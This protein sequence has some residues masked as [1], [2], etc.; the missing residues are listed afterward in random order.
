LSLKKF[1]SIAELTPIFCEIDY[2]LTERQCE[3]NGLIEYCQQYHLPIIVKHPLSQTKIN[4]I[5]GNPL[6][7]SLTKKYQKPIQSNILN[8]HFHK[9]G[10]H[11]WVKSTNKLHMDLNLSCMDFEIEDKDLDK[12]DH[13]PTT[14]GIW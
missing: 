3:K 4:E 5:A 2:G 9:E 12:I 6:I 11:A 1:I 10:I 7:L 8:W 14:H 13:F